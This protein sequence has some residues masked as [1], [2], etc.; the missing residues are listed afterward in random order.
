MRNFRAVLNL[1]LEDGIEFVTIKGKLTNV[2]PSNKKI[3]DMGEPEANVIFLSEKDKEKLYATIQRL[4]FRCIIPIWRMKV[5][6]FSVNQQMLDLVKVMLHTGLR[7]SEVVNLRKEHMID[8]SHI[9]IPS[10]RM[11]THKNLIDTKSP[12]PYTISLNNEIKPIFE[13]IK[14]GPIFPGWST[15]TINER[16]R[17]VADIAGFPELTPHGLRHTFATD[18]LARGIPIEIVSKMLNHSA[19]A[20][21]EKFYAHRQPG[22]LDK[23]FEALSTPLLKVA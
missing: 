23:Y 21:T 11:K 12:T 14:E 1:A 20:I 18:S 13:K 17:R 16:F 19:P 6:P 9:I 10:R 15:V 22:Y 7:R 4:Q 5:K 2:N 8:D 3:I